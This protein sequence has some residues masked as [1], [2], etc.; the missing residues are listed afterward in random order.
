M[1][2]IRRD[3]IKFFKS[4]WINCRSKINI[5]KH[6]SQR[7]NGHI[8]D[9]QPVFLI[10]IINLYQM[11]KSKTI[12]A[13][14]HGKALQNCHSKNKCLKNLLH[15]AKTRQ[16][17]HQTKFNF[18]FLRFAV[19]S[20]SHTFPLEKCGAHIFLECEYDQDPIRPQVPNVPLQQWL[21]YRPWPSWD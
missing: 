21:F 17:L 13:K 11:Q 2:I 8:L 12:M 19:R 14:K 18:F 20:V 16:R 7:L 1:A 3:K 5:G 4:I 15:F 6:Y 10:H 9:E